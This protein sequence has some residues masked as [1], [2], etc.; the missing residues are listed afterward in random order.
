MTRLSLPLH[1]LLGLLALGRLAGFAQILFQILTRVAGLHLGDVFWRAKGHDV[2]AAGA[3]FGTDIDDVVRG[4][5]HL[6]IMLDDDD[7]V[8]LVDQVMKDL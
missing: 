3:T 5:Y 4:F 6:K 7:R 2:A 8:A 1:T